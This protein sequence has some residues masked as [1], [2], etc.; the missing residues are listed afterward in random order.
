MA[1]KQLFRR[2]LAE[3][4]SLTQKSEPVLSCGAQKCEASIIIPPNAKLLRSFPPN[5][6]LLRSFPP[7]ARLLLSFPPNAKL[8]K[9][10]STGILW[11]SC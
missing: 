9:W 6:K 3:T 11:V 7:N 8:K 2:F 5:A 1:M 10:N 4:E